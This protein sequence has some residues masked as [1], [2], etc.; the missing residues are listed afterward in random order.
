MGR[1]RHTSDRGRVFDSR[2]TRVLSVRCNDVDLALCSMMLENLGIHPTTISDVVKKVL[3]SVALQAEQQIEETPSITEARSYLAERYGDVGTAKNRYTY[4]DA[5]S[6]EHARLRNGPE[7]HLGMR[8]NNMVLPDLV[9]DVDETNLYAGLSPREHA[10]YV[11]YVIQNKLNAS[12]FS[13]E[14]WKAAKQQEIQRATKEAMQRYNIGARQELPLPQPQQAQ[15]A[16]SEIPLG[17]DASLPIAVNDS[18][19]ELELRVQERMER[20][21]AEKLEM[22]RFMQLMKQQAQPEAGLDEM[23]VGSRSESE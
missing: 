14:D 8:Q 11:Q 21:K 22:E 18:P 2:S 12:T 15:Q 20:E 6:E 1:N 10:Q 4:N 16:E 13:P 23:E 5:A 7:F 3:L 9:P 19:E 17:C